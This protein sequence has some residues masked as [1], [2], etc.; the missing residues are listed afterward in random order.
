M[1]GIK[2]WHVGSGYSNR[3]ERVGTDVTGHDVGQGTTTTTANIKQP[4][5]TSNIKHNQTGQ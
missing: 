2:S 4:Q 1:K 3:W 5:A